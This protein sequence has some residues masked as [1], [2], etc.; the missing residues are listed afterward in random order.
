MKSSSSNAAH[1]HSLRQPDANQPTA[2]H[3]QISGVSNGDEAGGDDGVAATAATAEAAAVAGTTDCCE[4]LMSPVALGWLAV[5]DTSS[6]AS[7][8]LPLLPPLRSDSADRAIVS[9]L[10]DTEPTD[11]SDKRL[12]RRDRDDRAKKVKLFSN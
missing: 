11:K 10:A 2:D 8:S 4:A 1:A 12:D 5:V 9:A 6:S 7:L 3:S